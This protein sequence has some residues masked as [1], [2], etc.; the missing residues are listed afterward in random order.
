MS[1]GR[2]DHVNE[3]QQE[4]R[5]DEESNQQK[6][7]V[8]RDQPVNRPEEEDTST[9]EQPPPPTQEPPQVEVQQTR[10]SSWF[11]WS[12]L[13]TVVIE[14]STPGDQVQH[15]EQV[16]P[17]IEIIETQPYIPPEQPASWWL[18]LLSYTSTTTNATPESTSSGS[19]SETAPLL[20]NSKETHTQP[21]TSW[22]NWITGGRAAAEADEE[23]EDTS[24]ISNLELYKSAKSTIE[25]SKFDSHH[26]IFKNAINCKNIEL[27]V[28]NSL[29]E[30]N[31]VIYNSRKKPLLATEIL[32]NS[33][34]NGTSRPE[35]VSSFGSAIKDDT[36]NVV[37]PSF[38]ENYRRITLQT[39]LR[40]YSEDVLCGHK[41][42]FHLYRQKNTSKRAKKVRRITIIGVHSFLPNKM[43]RA[44]IG[45]NT[46]NANKFVNKASKAVVGWLKENN[47][48][49]NIN[50]YEIETLAIEG[51]GKVND[52][53]EKSMKLLRNNWLD[54]LENSDFIFMASYGTS[55]NLAVNLFAQM[56]IEFEPLQKIKYLG[57]LCM[58]GN[59]NG[60]AIGIDSKLV[61]RAFTSSENEIIK[62]LFELSNKNSK[63]SNQL[64]ESMKVLIENNVK[65]TLTGNANDLNFIPLSSSLGLQYDHPNIRR[66]IYNQGESC[67]PFISQLLNILCL[68]KNLGYYNDYGLI[69]D[70][71]DKLDPTPQQS[72]STPM[73]LEDKVY[74]EALKHSLETTNLIHAAEHEL[75]VKYIAKSSP[76]DN[77][78]N[79][80]PW[81]LRSLFQ[82]IMQ[83]KHINNLRLIVGLIEDFNNWKPLANG[84]KNFKD[85]KYCL[86]FLEDFEL[87]E[88]LLC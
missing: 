73:Y 57:L 4:M 58:N 59:L 52:R 11:F 72:S 85:I 67:V 65:I 31:P 51:E 30:D 42:E 15:Q 70:V 36:G 69:K 44:L 13:Q 7:L 80:L 49:F 25:S 1:S 23:E 81:N 17:Q 14:R 63:L 34:N 24:N 26:Y 48:E 87:T 78:Y 54:V 9:S 32:E 43:V 68:M 2:E 79:L 29:T 71:S 45:T 37:G 3:E 21:Q 5:S 55:C 33:I 77:F 8:L 84:N 82:D 39:K 16:P 60:P 61:V 6:Q 28:S 35:S 47:P 53:I 74:D 12:S 56:L 22:W 66:N 41:S 46:G 19:Q 40:I 27:S 18:S 50:D 76:D 75:L 62:E 10:V 64:N 83:I 38:D 20:N 88:L 86:S